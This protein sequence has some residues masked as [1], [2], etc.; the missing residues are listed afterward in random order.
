MLLG[1]AYFAAFLL[2][3]LHRYAWLCASLGSALA[4]HVAVTATADQTALAGTVA[5]LGSVVALFVLL[6][7]GLGDIGAVQRHR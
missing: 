3:N 4:I 7:L 6:I 5:F 2:A 1:G